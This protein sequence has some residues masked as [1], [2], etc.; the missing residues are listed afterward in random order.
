MKKMEYPLLREYAG[1]ITVEA[2][3]KI[4]VQN[5]RQQTESIFGCKVTIPSGLFAVVRS[6]SNEER[7]CGMSLK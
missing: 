2:K 7:D 1:I 4:S 6:T 5:R 3:S